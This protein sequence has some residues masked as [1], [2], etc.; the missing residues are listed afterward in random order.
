MRMRSSDVP[1]RGQVVVMTAF[2]LAAFM[3]MLAMA[4]DIGMMSIARNQCQ[5]AADLSAL[6]GARALNGY[7]NTASVTTAV[8]TARSVA[9]TNSVLTNPIV[10]S[11][12]GYNSGSQTATGISVGIYYYNPNRT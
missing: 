9:E 2:L 1:R 11:N 4:L 12:L 8:L 6:A 3:G 10:D 5:A 7:Q